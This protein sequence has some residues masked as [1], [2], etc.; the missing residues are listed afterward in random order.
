[1]LRRKESYVYILAGVVIAVCVVL[2]VPYALTEV[3]ERRV[4]F[5]F[6]VF[7]VLLEALVASFMA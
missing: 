2:G 6:P 1:M 4:S 3:Y 7:N 5:T